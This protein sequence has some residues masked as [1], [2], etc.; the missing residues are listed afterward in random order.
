MLFILFLN[1][2]FGKFLF[3]LSFFFL[4]FIF[5]MKRNKKLLKTGIMK[6]VHPNTVNT[7]KKMVGVINPS[8]NVIMLF[9]ITWLSDKIAQN[10]PNSS[11][12][13]FYMD[14]IEMYSPWATQM[15]AS[16]IPHM[17]APVKTIIHPTK[18][19]IS[20]QKLN[21]NPEMVYSENPILLKHIV[22]LYPK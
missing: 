14:I 21:I 9:P 8:T 12:L 11:G 19:G 13:W 3:F 10:N 7:R 18:W 5:E 4:I 20:G 17:A 6:Y 16:E 1:V 22:F 2:I 15:V